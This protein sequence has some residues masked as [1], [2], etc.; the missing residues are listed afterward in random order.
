MKKRAF[1]RSLQEPLQISAPMSCQH[2]VNMQIDQKSGK[3]LNV[4]ESV[5][6]VIPK[7]LVSGIVKNEDISPDMRPQVCPMSK[8]VF[9]ISNPQSFNHE[10]HVS[11]DSVTGFVG[12]PEW[13]ERQLKNSGINKQQVIEHA[14]E[15]LQVMNFVNYPEQVA[16]QQSPA[17]KPAEKDKSLAETENVDPK[18]FLTNI[19]QIGSGGTSTVFK[20]NITTLDNK[21]VAVKAIDMEQNERDIIQ[22]EIAVQRQLN[23]KNIVQIIKVCENKGWLYIIMEYVNGGTLTDILTTCCMT[24]LHIAFFVKNI[25]LALQQ[26][27]QNNLIHRDIKSDN[28]LVSKNGEVKIADFGYTARLTDASAKRTTICGTPYWMAPELIQ[29]NAYGSEVDIWSLGILCIEMAEGAPPYL[30]E[31]PMRALYL[32][33]VNGVRGLTEKDKWSPEF[34]DFISKCLDKIPSKRPKADELLKHP[35]L[36]NCSPVQEIAALERFTLA[37]KGKSAKTSRPF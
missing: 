14:E 25:L 12:L 34:N 8:D 4:P 23:H 22:N 19:T 2:V 7:T 31:Q 15:V 16:N 35:F 11:I 28:I 18:S 33:V 10:I 3:F 24:E 29:G 1:R 6:A 20:A 13:M 17:P 37:E 27:H 36:S 32:I 5:A 21:L 30:D 26:I 9:I